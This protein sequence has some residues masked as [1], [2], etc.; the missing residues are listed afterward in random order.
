MSAFDDFS[1]DGSSDTDSISFSEYRDEFS[2]DPKNKDYESDDNIFTM[3]LEAP[4]TSNA[5]IDNSLLLCTRRKKQ[6]ARPS[7]WLDTQRKRKI[8]RNAGCAYV[9]SISNTVVPARKLKPPC[10][11]RCRVQCGQKITEL[12]RELLFKEYWGLRDINRQREFINK[13]MLSIK[14]KYRYTTTKK[15]RKL[16][17]AF[18]FTIAEQRIRVCKA[19]FINTLDI[20]ARAIQ[21]V[22]DKRTSLGTIEEDLRGKHRN[23]RGGRIKKKKSK[24]NNYQT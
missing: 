4:S 16:N 21:T 19:F 14:P 3:N 23:H 24:N 1:S 7:E 9:S 11:E 5:Q 10:G 13:H 8:L 15:G 18:Y 17:N 22:I 12:D 20:S 6:I 2:P